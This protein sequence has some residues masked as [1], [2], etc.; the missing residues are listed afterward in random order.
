MRSIQ[1]DDATYAALWAHWQEGDQGELGIIRRLLN[2]KGSPLTPPRSEIGYV[3][4]RSGTN[5]VQGFE[6]FRTFKHTKYRAIAD[7]GIWR[8]EDGRTAPSLNTLSAMIGARTENAW[9][10]WYYKSGNKV[11]LITH[12]RPKKKS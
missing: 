1:L 11:A 3:D 7:N 4:K 9:T 8:L 12:L 2:M 5:F 10:G 6:I